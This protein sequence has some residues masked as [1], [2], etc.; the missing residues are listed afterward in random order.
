VIGVSSGAAVAFCWALDPP[1]GAVVVV[2]VSV[3]GV[4]VVVVVGAVVVVVVVASPEVPVLPVFPVAPVVAWVSGAAGVEPSTPKVNAVAPRT[5]IVARPRPRDARPPKRRLP[6]V[7]F[8]SG[9]ARRPLRKF[10]K[11]PI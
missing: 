11:A 1:V 6:E 2:V 4:V 7:G 3:V 8:R 10:E 5:V 9:R